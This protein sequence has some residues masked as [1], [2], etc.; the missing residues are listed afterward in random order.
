MGGGEM[1]RERGRETEGGREIER[2]SEKCKESEI[3]RIRMR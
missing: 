1:D 3:E 2:Q